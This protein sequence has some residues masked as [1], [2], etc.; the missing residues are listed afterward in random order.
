MNFKQFRLS[1]FLERQYDEH[2]IND[3]DS[4]KR[5][6]I[7]TKGKGI[8]V[9]DEVPGFEIGTKRQF[10][11]K[12][13]QFL[14]SK[15]DAMNGAFGIVPPSCNNGI[16]T[17]NFWTFQINSEVILPKYLELLSIGEVFS[18]FSLK[19]STGTTNRKY[20][21]EEAFLDLS[22]SLPPIHEQQRIIAKLDAIRSQLDR[23]RTLRI[24]QKQEVKQFLYSRFLD[25]IKKTP[26]LSIHQVAPV[27]RTPVEIIPEGE[28]EELGVR[29]FGR[30]VFHK[31]TLHGID[32]TWQKLYLIS[33][34]DLVISNIKAWE[35][36]IAVA[37]KNDDGR[38]AS[39]RYLTCKTDT[40]QLLPKFLCSYLLYPEGLEKIRFASPG[41]ADRNRTLAVKRLEKIMVPIPP[42]EKQVEFVNLQEGVD[43]LMKKQIAQ[44]TEL[45]ELFSSLLNKAFRGEL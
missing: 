14:L 30:G 17:G 6:T 31:P 24:E 28:Y 27:V 8:S 29:G 5:I 18:S 25:T 42:I 2:I 32:L 3:T 4:Y 26:Y 11:V 34:G 1:D 37:T 10:Y 40:N 19:A 16:V 38:V 43:R 41:S 23:L 12:E 35:G 20:L 36:A 13:G 44:Q 9:R 15:I 7:R 22:I 33:E 39:H 45:D 21:N